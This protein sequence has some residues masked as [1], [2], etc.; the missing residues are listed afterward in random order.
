MRIGCWK[1]DDLSFCVQWVPEG[2]N[3]CLFIKHLLVGPLAVFFSR[4]QE[5]WLSEGSAVHLLYQYENCISPFP[6]TWIAPV[7]RFFGVGI[8]NNP[9]RTD[10]LFCN[11]ISVN[12][13][14]N[15]HRIKRPGIESLPLA[16]GFYQNSVIVSFI[17]SWDRVNVAMGWSVRNTNSIPVFFAAG[18]MSYK[19]PSLSCDQ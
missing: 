19:V 7:M 12:I 8:K 9:A 14:V 4:W 1:S 5:S 3:G 11:G 15:D 16:S 18:I 13:P 10:Y 6:G 2:Q 17:A